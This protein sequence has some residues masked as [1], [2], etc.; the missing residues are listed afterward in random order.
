MNKKYITTEAPV[1]ETKKYQDYLKNKFA[2]LESPEAKAHI[3]KLNTIMASVHTILS[4][5]GEDTNREGL[6]ETP[7]RVAK[8]FLD[9]NFSGY[10]Q[11]LLKIA[12]SASFSSCKKGNVVLVKDIEFYSTCEHHMMPFFG[13]MHV[14]YIPK[15]KVLGLSKIPRV[16]KMAARKLQL[17]ENLGQEVADAIQEA[18]GSD[19]VCVIIDSE[20]HLCVSMR[21]V[22]DSSNTVTIA[23]AGRDKGWSV[24]RET[25]ISTVFKMLGR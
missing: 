4:T 18:S 7:L 6:I 5:L 16:A 15:D 14:A 2:D 13:R 17:Q 1:K 10:D 11:D 12:G 3:A 24:D 19:A 25:F 20:K 21:G 8:M 9:E 22:K 23:T